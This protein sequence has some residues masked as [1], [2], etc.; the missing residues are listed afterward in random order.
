M[1]RHRARFWATAS[2]P[3]LCRRPFRQRPLV[4]RRL[5][6]QRPLVCRRLFRQRPLACRRLFRQRL[7]VCRR[8]FRQRPLV[9]RRLFRQRPSVRNFQCFHSLGFSI[10]SSL[11]PLRRGTYRVK[12]GMCIVVVV[13]VA[14][15]WY[16]QGPSTWNQSPLVVRHVLSFPSFQFF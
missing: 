8:L 14:V 9:C 10:Q 12:Q 3:V 4:C 6:R 5:Y 7:L 11:F 13:V 2:I 16:Q 15:V 1:H